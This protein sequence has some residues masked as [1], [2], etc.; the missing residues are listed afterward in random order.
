MDGGG[1]IWL[2]SIRNAKKPSGSGLPDLL[3]DLL[4]M[5]RPAIKKYRHR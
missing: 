1:I 3:H 5:L 4:K 2:G